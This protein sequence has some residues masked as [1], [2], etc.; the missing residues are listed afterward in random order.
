MKDYKLLLAGLILLLLV[1]IIGI[2]TW[3][4]SSNRKNMDP[5]P[6]MANTNEETANINEDDPETVNT[7]ILYVQAE[8]KL[9]SAL[10]DVIARFE[11]RYPK[12][13]IFTLYVNANK[14]LTLPSTSNSDD[15]GVNKSSGLIFNTDIIMANDKISKERLAP[16]QALLKES[17]IERNKNS[18]NNNTDISKVTE[19]DDENAKTPSPNDNKEARNLSSF[20]YALRNSEAVDGVILTENPTAIS[21]RN[22][23]LSSVGQDILKQHDYENIEG[24]RNNLNDLF[25][26]T[27][28]AKPAS[29][30]STVQVAD[31]LS[32]GQ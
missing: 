21:F 24:Y 28:Q 11:S 29:N 15:N 20:S 1:I 16:L 19:N 5:L 17:Q 6:I 13:Q 26:P 27:S 8:D 14:L 10:N 30:E 31:A 2:F 23:L 18:I 32:N 3:L 25:S 7:A 9:Q 22:F 4:W 12:V